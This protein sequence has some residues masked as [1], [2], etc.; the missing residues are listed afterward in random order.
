METIQQQH[1]KYLPP[2]IKLQPLQKWGLKRPP[3]MQI[4]KYLPLQAYSGRIEKYV[5]NY[6][7]DLFCSYVRL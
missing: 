1:G 5:K 7:A 4:K 3:L 2:R 6:K